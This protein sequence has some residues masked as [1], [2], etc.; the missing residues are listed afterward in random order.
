MGTLNI[1]VYTTYVRYGINFQCLEQDFESFQ[2]L[3]EFALVLQS[4][5]PLNTTTASYVE[6]LRQAFPAERDSAYG[7][8][9]AGSS[10]GS[11]LAGSRQLDHLPLT[12]TASSGTGDDRS[13]VSSGYG[14]LSSGATNCSSSG[15]WSLN[16]QLR[17]S[18]LTQQFSSVPEQRATRSPLA[19][20]EARSIEPSSSNTATQRSDS[21]SSW[22]CTQHSTG[23]GS[24][25]L[26]SAASSST[27]NSRPGV[28]SLPTQQSSSSSAP[29]SRSNEQRGA[30][31]VLF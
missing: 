9:I 7:S 12:F 26:Q 20:N 1:L 3:L 27:S 17:P 29:S 11:G 16:P 4:Q 18:S 24:T 25:P 31:F 14:S 28:K 2:D 21:S 23:S 5:V 30:L 10:I 6:Q 19:R 22:H 13:D 15:S 8:S